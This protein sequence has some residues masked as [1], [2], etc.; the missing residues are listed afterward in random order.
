MELR[1]YQIEARDAVLNEWKEN[2][3]TLIVL[4]TGAGK[5][6]IFSSIINE[7]IKNNPS[8]HIL[9][10]AH[11]DELIRQA[12][13]KLEKVTGII[14][15]IEKAQ[16]TVVN[17]KENYNVVVGSVQSMA[18]K[19]LE[20]Y[21]VNFFTHIVID[22]AHH[23]VGKTYDTVL[24]HFPDAKILGVT[25]TPKRADKKSLIRVFDSICYEY[26]LKSAIRDKY[27]CPIKA[28]CIPIN[29]DITDV[30]VNAGDFAPG[31]LSNAIEPYLEEIATKMESICV[32]KKTIVFTP[33]IR[34]SKL[35]A[36]ILNN[37]G[38]RAAEV[39]GQSSDRAEILNDFKEGKYNVLTNAMLATEGYD[40]PSVDCIIVLRPTK[41]TGLYQ[42]M[43]GRGTRLYPGKEDLLILDFL[44]LTKQHDLCHPASLVASTDEIAKKMCHLINESGA[45][46]DLESLEG[47]AMMC[48]ERDREAALAAQLENLRNSRA[49][50]ISSLQFFASLGQ[51]QL[52]D[53]DYIYAWEEEPPTEKQLMAIQNFGLDV[54][55]ITTKGLASRILD[56]LNKRIK[57]N[58]SSIKQIKL[59][60]R[61][62]FR[63]V[64]EWTF[65]EASE[66]IDMIAKNKWRVPYFIKV[67]TY[68]PKSK[69]INN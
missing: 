13:D 33:L 10:L 35:F 5:T 41:S 42:Q 4:S 14:A 7:V 67:S 53:A 39:N 3:K 29:L 50:F 1:P 57:D 45:P 59:L 36:E 65:S 37:H 21:P 61:Y 46:Q 40:E 58:L 9:V 44:W 63:H 22:E 23:A 62:G 27:L 17:E 48:I 12:A 32:D 2:D 60:E 30:S 26:D 68:I 8:A 54:S 20:E 15:G 49:E 31:E 11:R 24:S 16:E 64:G 55:Q 51:L 34:T 47:E 38:F 18:G 25:A 56:I 43:I 19:R 69:R 6:I 52:L 66:M 28:Q